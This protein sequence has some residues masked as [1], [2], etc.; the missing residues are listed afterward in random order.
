MISIRIIRNRDPSSSS[1]FLPIMY[2]EVFEV[3][4]TC[5]GR[6]H[7]LL[8]VGWLSTAMAPGSWYWCA[9]SHLSIRQHETMTGWW[10]QP[11][12]KI[13]V[14]WDDYSQ[15][16]VKKKTHVSKPPT[17]WSSCKLLMIPH[18]D[19]VV[20][21]F[22]PSHHQTFRL[23]K[24]FTTK[25]LVFWQ[26]QTKVPKYSLGRCF[27]HP[28]PHWVRGRRMAQL[29]RLV[30]KENISKWQKTPGNS[31][32]NW[33]IPKFINFIKFIKLVKFIKLQKTLLL[34]HHILS[35]WWV[36]T[37][38]PR[39]QDGW[40]PNKILG[41]KNHLS[42]GAW[43][44]A[45]P[46]TEIIGMEGYFNHHRHHA[47]AAWPITDSTVFPLA[48]WNVKIFLPIRSPYMSKMGIWKCF[49]VIPFLHISSGK[50]T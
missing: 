20:F 46:S 18:H 19:P 7:H 24:W 25:I 1:S 42:S 26:I 43:D 2:R 31:L 32:Q 8:E 50:L 45:G 23:P 5:C 13:L 16:M 36:R 47:P 17:R 41:C 11:L 14:S 48:M 34:Y 29:L 9:E 44:F 12:W 35:Y 27:S 40:N 33:A 6:C 22:F 21:M 30:A 28:G 38:A 49:S 37:P 3:V 15:S 4:I 39:H 10:F